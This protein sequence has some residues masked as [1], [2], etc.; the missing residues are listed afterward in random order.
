MY[1]HTPITM[2]SKNAGGN[3]NSNLLR[4]NTMCAS[5]FSISS[6][7]RVFEQ[8]CWKKLQSSIMIDEMCQFK[9]DGDQLQDDVT[10]RHDNHGT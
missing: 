4:T 8:I 1:F 7:L 5:T 2:I 3:I 9:K 10:L 6:T